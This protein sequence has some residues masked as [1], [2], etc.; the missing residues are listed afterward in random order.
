VADIIT[1]EQV[2][3]LKQQSSDAERKKKLAQE[4]Q[5][6]DFINNGQGVIPETV[7]QNLPGKK[8]GEQNG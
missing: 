2:S 5:G 7:W 8:E 6:K 4:K 1:D 3:K